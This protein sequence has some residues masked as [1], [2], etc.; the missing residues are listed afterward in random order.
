MPGICAICRTGTVLGVGVKVM[1]KTDEVCG[2]MER[3]VE[4][5]R[6]NIQADI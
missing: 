5:D 4:G 1:N 2:L 6:E 3:V